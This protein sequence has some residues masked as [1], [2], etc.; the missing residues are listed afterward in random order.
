MG[1]LT[2]YDRSSP[3]LDPVSLRCRHSTAILPRGL[4]IQ[5]MTKA[6]RDWVESSLVELII[7]ICSMLL[8]TFSRNGMKMRL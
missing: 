6:E 7:R 4:A 3:R 8:N 5:G 2:R 1:N